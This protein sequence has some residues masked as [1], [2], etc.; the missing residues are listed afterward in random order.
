MTKPIVIGFYG[1]SNSGKTTL[2]EKVI[3]ELASRGKKVATIKYSGHAASMDTQGKDTHRFTQAG[4]DP[5]VLSSSLETTI[6]ISNPLELKKILSLLMDVQ[7]ID[8]I[9]IEGAKEAGVR[10]I[11]IGDIE[12]RENTTWTYDGN[13]DLLIEKI[14]NGGE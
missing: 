8:I 14:L 11:R 6:K 10:K 5:V 2:I 7:P 4:A 1:Y 13:F 3:K 9:I 12:L